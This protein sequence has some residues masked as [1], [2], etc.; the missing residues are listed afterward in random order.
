[1]I[2]GGPIWSV[3]Q[4]SPDLYDYPTNHLDW[5]TLDSRHFSVHFQEGNSR[6]A[7]VVS[8]I[9]EEVFPGITRL[10]EY[11]PD[12]KIDIVLRD[13]EDYSNGAA[14]F[15]D[16]QIDIWVP[17]LNTPLRGTHDWLKD[18][19]THEFTHIIQLGA[20]MKRS[21]KFPALY[22]QWLSYED[23]RRPDVLYGYPNGIITHPF[24]SI[25]IPA[26]MAEGFAQYQRSGWVFDTWDSHRDMVLR[27]SILNDNWLGFEDMSIFTSKNSLEREQIYNQGFAFTAWLVQHYGEDIL[28][29]ITREFSKPGIYT[30]GEALEQVTSTRGEKLFSKWIESRKSFYK[31]AI[32]GIN[33]SS[34]S[35]LEGNGFYNFEPRY[36]PDGEKIA[37]LSNRGRDE[38][39]TSLY[40]KDRKSGDNRAL[41]DLGI[42]NR[43]TIENGFSSD[44]VVETIEQSYDFS[45]GGERLVFTRNVL[46]RLGEEYNDLFVY[47]LETGKEKRLTRSARMW[48][49]AW[50]PDGNRI[51]AIQQKNGTLNLV[52]LTDQGEVIEQLTTYEDGE[53]VYNPAWHPDG[54]R[55]YFAFS[56]NHS[57]NILLY[58]L[59]MNET[60]TVLEDPWVD[61]RDPH[62]DEE[63]LFLYYSADPDGIFNI[64]RKP[65][66]EAGREQL[67][68]VL[69][70][71]F[72]PDTDSQG[73]LLFSLYGKNGYKIASGKMPSGT[74]NFGFY[75]PPVPQLSGKFITGE[76]ES[77]LRSPAEIPE[78]DPIPDSLLASAGTDSMAINVPTS[79]GQQQRM[80]KEYGDSFTSVS[81]NP[82]IRF[83]NYS[84][85]NGSNANLVKA[86]HF[87]AL[88]E[89]LMRDMKLGTY[90]S[91]REVTGRLSIFGG[92]MIGVGSLP[93]DGIGDFFNPSRLTDLDRDLFLI[94]EYEGLPF[95]KKHW[96]PTVSIEFYNLRRNVRDG[97]A[98]EEFPCTACLPDTLHTDIAYNIWEANLYLR[99][100]LNKSN[101][102]E[103]GVSYSPYRVETGGFFSRE[104]QQFIPASSSEYF[105]ST[106]LS[107]AWVYEAFRP[108]RHSDTAPLGL[109]TYVKYTY[110]PAKLLEDYE[111]R[112]GILSPVYRS[113]RNHSIELSGRYGLS[114]TENSSLLLH[115]RIFSY[116]NR[117]RD[118]FYQDYIGG[119]TGMRSYPYFALG[120]ATTAFGQLSYNFPLVTDIN[121]QAGPYTADKLFA[122]FFVEAGNGW[123]T[124]L[125]IGASVKTGIG[126]ELRFAFNSYYLF[127]MKLFISGAWG[128]NQFEVSLPDEFITGTRSGRV[129]YGRELLFHF[130]L[131]F[132]F[133]T[134]NL[135]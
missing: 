42:L 38:S 121:S 109:R 115:S 55:I 133:N 22:L 98:I 132:D 53:Q 88:G 25:N 59:E 77:K 134:L 11:E 54:N 94:T 119:F 91:S 125:D 66:N 110:Q 81:F 111:V 71:A 24:V 105:R 10:Y 100:K 104:L 131:T 67:T 60:K 3:A 19:V 95:I 107:A 36:S 128:L 12:T 61:F 17:A 73:N 15:F 89:N 5:Y 51:A 126:T 23:V 31:E 118:Y 45:P 83:D 78:F 68:S 7:Q 57:R 116:L 99:S 33:T 14:Y 41:L 130:G 113:N 120:G 18:V 75:N 35:I 47:T 76:R 64:Y 97:L 90:F 72:M 49:P 32:S 87:G 65:V 103:L 124:P 80:L 44:P 40:I 43:Q 69:G 26:W 37:Y 135:K 9:A 74:T 122:R 127:P 8:S 117:P 123:R 58:D 39:R 79:S 70:G 85:L 102:V 16:N 129:Q 1:M 28:T 108:Y 27:S 6:T 56:D 4:L 114:I 2:L 93:A 48:A 96:S 46:T 112:E 34:H 21:R 30:A 101:L 62:V 86:G 50:S 20:A 82:V 52:L 84:K 106:V 63:G 13:R 92:A 29:N